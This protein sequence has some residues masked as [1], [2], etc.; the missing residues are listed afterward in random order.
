MM[1][2]SGKVLYSKIHCLDDFLFPSGLK[3]SFSSFTFCGNSVSCQRR[4]SQY[5]PCSCFTGLRLHN[6]VFRLITLC[7]YQENNGHAFIFFISIQFKV[8]FCPCVR[9]TN[10]IGKSFYQYH[11]TQDD[12]RGCLIPSSNIYIISL[13]KLCDHLCFRD[14]QQ[15]IRDLPIYRSNF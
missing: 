10:E 3:Q 7:R 13:I 2:K 4:S 14:Y 1:A 5:K 12:L 9:I 11:L 15:R 6:K 8:E